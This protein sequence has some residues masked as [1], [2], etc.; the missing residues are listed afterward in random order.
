MVAA[1]GV[2][3]TLLLGGAP[4]LAQTDADLAVAKSDSPDPVVAGAN[5][6][7]QST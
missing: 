4:A 7:Y 5:L 3:G 1:A 6:S 2:V